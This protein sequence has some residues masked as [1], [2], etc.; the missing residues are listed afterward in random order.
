MSNTKPDPY[1]SSWSNEQL[2]ELFILRVKIQQANIMLSRGNNEAEW[3]QFCDN[4]ENCRNEILRRMALA[5][6]DPAP[7]HD[8]PPAPPAQQGRQRHGGDPGSPEPR[9]GSPIPQQRRRMEDAVRRL[10]ELWAR[11]FR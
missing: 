11:V 10:P 4:V 7:S 8:A 2:L 1:F 5:S 6:P 3:E 9:P